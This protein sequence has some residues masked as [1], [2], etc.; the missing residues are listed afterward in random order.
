MLCAGFSDVILASFLSVNLIL[1]TNSFFSFLP[2]LL[3]YVLTFFLVTLTGQTPSPYSSLSKE[4]TFA[5]RPRTS[6]KKTYLQPVPIMDCLFINTPKPSAQHL[7]PSI[8]DSQHTSVSPV[9]FRAAP[10]KSA[11]LIP[12]D[13]AHVG[14]S[15]GGSSSLLSDTSSEHQNTLE[16]A[17]A[18]PSS[19]VGLKPNHKT[20]TEKKVSSLYVACLS[21][22]TCSAASENSTA[23][24]HVQ[25]EGTRFGAE[26]TVA[27][28]INS[29]S[30]VMDTGKSLPPPSS[31][32]PPPAP[33]RPF[34]NIVLGRD[35]V[36]YGEK[37]PSRT[38]QLVDNTKLESPRT[39]GFEDR[40]RHE[41]Y[42]TR[43]QPTQQR[44]QHPCK[45][46]EGG[47]VHGSSHNLFF[48]SF[49]WAEDSIT[50]ST[51]MLTLQFPLLNTTDLG[52][53]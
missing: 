16:R 41:L 1:M 51:N 9:P 39:T 36:S 26:V 30:S 15:L 44:Q 13:R 23:C 32:P 5:W 24:A 46:K 47:R 48:F 28:A 27:P 35:A 31:P 8:G 52:V 34:F 6:T 43:Q 49:H 33:P 4:E 29:V 50:C 20:R 18:E 12:E 42:V 45:A 53:L 37:H 3:L 19:L 38:P 14:Q 25:T 21:N 7:P 2:F 22:S 11:S 17:E 40:M 10:H